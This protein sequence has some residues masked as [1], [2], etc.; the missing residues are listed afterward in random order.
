MNAE[1][2]YKTAVCTEYERLLQVCVQSLNR[3][4]NR[5]DEIADSGLKGKEVGDELLRL[6]ADYVKAYSRLEKHEDSCALC[7]FVSK[8]GGRNYASIS[9]GVLDKKRL[10]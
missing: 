7:Q 8:I 10:A 1:L 2:S 5:R 6:Q 3:W 4:R 9:T